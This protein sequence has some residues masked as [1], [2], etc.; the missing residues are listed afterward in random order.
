M[1]VPGINVPVTG[2]AVFSDTS[3][4]PGPYIALF[5]ITAVVFSA[6]SELSGT[7]TMTGLTFPAGSWIYGNISNFTMTSGSVR[8]YRV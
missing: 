5:C 7:G 1:N 2:V 3:A 6:W 4:H 8:A